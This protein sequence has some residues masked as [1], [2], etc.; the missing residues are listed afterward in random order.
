MQ[1]WCVVF[2]SRF[3]KNNSERPLDVKSCKK[4]D[5][6]TDNLKSRDA[7]ASKKSTYKKFDPDVTKSS[8]PD[9]SLEFSVLCRCHHPHQ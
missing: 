3:N 6:L 9:L 7:S 1:C 5:P 4:G 8:V 2:S